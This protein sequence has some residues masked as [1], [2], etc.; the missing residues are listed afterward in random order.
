MN[1]KTEHGL[2]RFRGLNKISIMSQRSL[3][4]F[5]LTLLL[6]N[7]FLPTFSAP[8]VDP[9]A[10]IGF[11]PSILNPAINGYVIN[12]ANPNSNGLSHNKYSEFNVASNESI[13][14]NNSTT[15]GN[16]QLLNLSLLANPNL[17]SGSASTILNEVTGLN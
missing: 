3:S 12:I 14:F 13:I 2:S 9:N 10:P 17:T 15:G 1:N 5:L 8:V 6:T 7:L 16:T 11:Q 4:L